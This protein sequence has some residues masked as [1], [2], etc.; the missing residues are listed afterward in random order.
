M[1]IF[2][3]LFVATFALV[4]SYSVYS[5]LQNTEMSDLAM[6]NVEALAQTEGSDRIDCVVAADMCTEL[7]IY[8]DG[9]GEDILFDHTKKIGWL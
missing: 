1:K 8:P 9:W 7:V 2:K 6:A 3:T 5:T 4:A